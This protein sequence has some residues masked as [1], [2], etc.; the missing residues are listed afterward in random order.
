[1]YQGG[2]VSAL[3]PLYEECLGIAYQITKQKVRGMNG[4]AIL[5]PHERL[6][7]IAH[8][9]SVRLIQRYLEKPDFN[10]RHFAKSLDFMVQKEMFIPKGS[11]QRSF[12][13]AISIESE[14]DFWERE[15]EIIPLGC[16]D[17]L[18]DIAFNHPRGRKMAADLCRSRS[19]RQAIRRISEYVER[20]WIYDHATSLHE[21]YRALHRKTKVGGISGSGLG[22]VRRRILQ[23]KRDKQEQASKS[24]PGDA[25]G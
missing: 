9:A 12:E 2:A 23:S 4:E 5:Y 14:L 24:S 3:Q 21:V 11:K 15:N 8:G 19:Y 13:A 17:K 6:V 1:M 22:A 18:S 16:D 7:E 25:Q 10:C 20:E